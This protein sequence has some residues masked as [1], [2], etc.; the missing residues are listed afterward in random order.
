MEND[1]QHLIVD[2]KKIRAFQEMGADKIKWCVRTVL[3]H[4][5]GFVRVRKLWSLSKNRMIIMTITDY[6]GATTARTTWWTR[7][8]S[9]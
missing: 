2:G 5:V 8:A 9:T 4:S 6:I 3:G 7:R 1:D